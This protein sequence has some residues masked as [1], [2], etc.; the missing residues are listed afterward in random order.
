MSDKLKL[1]RTLANENENLLKVLSDCEALGIAGFCG[2]EC[3]VYINGNCP[4]SKEQKIDKWIKGDD[5][6]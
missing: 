3:D 6:S 4:E 5:E 1:A 2:R